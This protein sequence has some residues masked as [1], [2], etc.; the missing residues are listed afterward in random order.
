MSKN[1]T[2]KKIPTQEIDS[3]S[4]TNDLAGYSHFMEKEIF[5]QPKALQDALQGRVASEG[6]QEGILVQGFE[7]Q[8]KDVTNIQ[9]VAC[10][11]ASTLAGY[12]NF[13]HINF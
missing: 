1:G 12:L 6:T 5:E 11:Q 9:I 7:D 13:G 10:A 2:A 4:F 8:V 3:N